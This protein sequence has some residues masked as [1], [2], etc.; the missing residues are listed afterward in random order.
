MTARLGPVLHA[1]LIP[2]ARR[3]KMPGVRV[4]FATD[5]HGSETCW[6]NSQIP[7][8][9]AGPPRGVRNVPLT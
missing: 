2:T 8:E 4:F 6:R 9:R 5:I 3:A 1:G 7:V